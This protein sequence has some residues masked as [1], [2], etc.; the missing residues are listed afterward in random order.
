[1]SVYFTTVKLAHSTV[2]VLQRQ[3]KGNLASFRFLL[4]EYQPV[5]KPRVDDILLQLLASTM[6]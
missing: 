5:K 3:E 4:P 1:M 2:L 6:N